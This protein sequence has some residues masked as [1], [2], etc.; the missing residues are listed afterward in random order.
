MEKTIIHIET[1]VH[2]PVQKVWEL[3]N[4]E[5][6]ITKWNQASPNWFCPSAYVDLRVGGRFKSRMEAKD[7]SFGF[8]FEGEFTEVVPYDKISYRLDD[9]R[10]VKIKFAPHDNHTHMFIEFE[11]ESMNPVEMQ[12]AGWHAILNSFKNYTENNNER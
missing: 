7:G 10:N 3:Y 2:A 8:D 11:A 4:S 9:D 12:Q 5:E 1:I 6:A